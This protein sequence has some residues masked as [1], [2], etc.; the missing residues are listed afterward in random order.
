MNK[1]KFLVSMDACFV[2][3]M[4]SVARCGYDNDH[5]AEHRTKYQQRDLAVLKTYE[6]LLTVQGGERCGELYGFLVAQPACGNIPAAEY[7]HTF[8]Q[9]A[10]MEHLTEFAQPIKE[11]CS[12]MV[13]CY[14]IFM[15]QVWPQSKLVIRNY[16]E[17]LIDR[18]EKSN[19]TDLAEQVVDCRLNT[20]YFY[21]VMTD[22]MENGAEAIDI[23]VDKDVFSI[24]RS[25]DH[26][27]AFIAH[28][29]V[30]YLL[31]S[32]LRD[33]SAFKSFKTWNITEALAEFYLQ[34]ILGD[35]G[36]F[37]RQNKWIRFYENLKI[38]NPT[39]AP[40]ALYQAAEARL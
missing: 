19:F 23:S 12:V 14:P 24:T 16:V 32:A 28:E 20:P 7:Y 13:Q 22:S 26:A 5:G 9:S 34:Q 35:T 21:A 39:Y 10:H 17:P 30:I 37:Q 38:E 31:K 25:P 2:Y 4:L 11:I 29:Y 27:Y 1:I 18:F 6:S 33:S 36:T 3:H 15:E 8:P 40:V